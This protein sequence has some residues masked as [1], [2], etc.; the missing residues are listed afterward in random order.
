MKTIVQSQKQGLLTLFDSRNIPLARIQTGPGGIQKVYYKSLLGELAF[1]ELVYRKPAEGYSFQPVDTFT[2]GNVRD[3][4]APADA[5]VQEALRR[6]SEIPNAFTYLGGSEARY[7][8]RIE[9]YDASMAS[10]NVQWFAE[11][12]WSCIDGYLTLDNLP[13][14]SGAD[15]YTTLQAVREMVNK[16]QISL[17]NRVPFHLSGQLGNPLVSHTDFEV[18]AWDP[19]QAFFLDP[20]SGRPVWLPGNF[21]GVA[22]A[23]Q[24]KNMLHTVQIQL[25]V[26][27]AMILKDYKLIGLHSGPHTPKPGQAL[28]PFQGKIYQ[29]MWM[30]ALLDLTAA[31]K[32]REGD[33]SMTGTEAI[34][35]LR[36][37]ALDELLAC[38]RSTNCRNL[39]A[40]TVMRRTLSSDRASTVA[41]RSTLLSRVW[42]QKSNHLPA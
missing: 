39:S 18:H 25:V 27:G 12:L 11:R 29:M 22:N 5:L 32:G 3:I 23:L 13:E 28:P 24:P 2:W 7:Q 15:T 33:A 16:A 38:R 26:P 6:A 20:L 1:F 8:Q 21:F 9:N 37:K 40:P 19:L 10:E 4:T 35:G 14:R 42:K 36:N 41:H 31:K 30:G 34:S 17:I